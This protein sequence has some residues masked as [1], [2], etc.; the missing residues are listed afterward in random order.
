MHLRTSLKS[1]LEIGLVASGA[2]AM[3]RRRLRRQSLILAYHNVVPHGETTGGDRSL[4]IAQRVFADHLDRLASTH[5][6]VPLEEAIALEPIRG[7][8]PRAA[9]TFDDAYRGAVTAGIAE[10]VGR[11][12][13]A[14]LF[15]APAFVGDGVF[16]WDA[17]AH[18][19]EG[20]QPAVRHHVLDNLAGSTAEALAWAR[21]EDRQVNEAL[22]AHQRCASLE[23]LAVAERKPGIR[24]GSHTWS[25]ANLARLGAT[26][27]RDELERSR[28]WLS[29]RFTNFSSVLSY[30]YGLR[31]AASDDAAQ[32]AGYSAALRVA[33]GWY[34]GTGSR[35][36][37][38]R[39]NVPAHLSPRGLALRG[40][41]FF[42]R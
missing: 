42:C 36:Q 23:E 14:T 35:F 34:A 3:S 1:A 28:E 7:A 9:L 17:L 30:P 4:H 10:V 11:G 29:T 25:H 8:R 41:G 24:V 26:A 2:A 13:P 21:R 12:L 39:V 27:L 20:L 15:V 37:I 22:P 19:A 32:A 6:I 38:P 33:G 31:S 18:P 16:W 40:A 5:D